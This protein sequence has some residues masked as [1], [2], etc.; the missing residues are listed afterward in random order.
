MFKKEDREALKN[1]KKDIADIEYTLWKKNNLNEN[2]SNLEKEIETLKEQK[3][4]FKLTDSM[5]KGK[6]FIM[7][8]PVGGVEKLLYLSDYIDGKSLYNYRWTADK[9]KAY[10]YSFNEAYRIKKEFCASNDS[11]QN[12][13]IVC[14]DD[15][16]DEY[17]PEYTH[18]LLKEEEKNG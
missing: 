14:V 2:I 15:I 6:V 4:S 1:I 17:T 3:A 12:L 9:K 8:T 16:I 10:P 18:D 11:N 7:R 13:L 5:Y